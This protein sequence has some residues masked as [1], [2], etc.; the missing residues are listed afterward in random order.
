M[1]GFHFKKNY[2]AIFVTSTILAAIAARILGNCGI[3][4]MELGLL[5]TTLYIVLYII[6]GISLR[7]RIIHTHVRRYLTAVAVLMVF[8]FVVRTMKY[9]FVSDAFISRNLWYS[10]YIPILFIPLLALFVALSLGKPESYRLPKWAAVPAAVTAC[11]TAP[12][13]TNDFHQLVFSFPND[14]V[15]SDK[16]HE[17]TV[18]F[19]LIIGWVFACAIASFA[20]MAYKCRT[21]KRKKYLPVILLVL[22]VIYSFVYSTGV[23]W[24]RIIAGDTAAAQCL[25]FTAI[26]ESCIF[27]G[28]IQTN[29][30]YDSLFKSCTLRM[31]IADKSR[32]IRFSSAGAQALSEELMQGAEKATVPLDKNTLLKSAEIEGGR[33]YWQ[34]DIAELTAVIDELEEN[35]RQ[36]EERNYLAQENYETQRRIISLREKNRLYDILQRHTAPQ[37]ALLD[38]IFAQYEKEADE[39]KRHLL[40]VTAVIG[41]Y[42]K[43][44]GNLLFIGEKNEFVE[45]GELARCIAESLTYLELMGVSCGCDT[46]LNDALRTKDALRAYHTFESIIEAALNSLRFLWLK[47]KSEAEHISLYIE[48]ECDTDLSALSEIADD[49]SAEDG[50]F[51][52]TVRLEKGGESA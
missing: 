32:N 33:V 43:R 52:F 34:E 46:E 24:V 13:L 26:F 27:C 8:W 49:F 11:C 16:N 21:S 28:L 47:A 51:R 37:I 12:V 23:K 36:L 1:T 29:S 30:G 22:E 39:K 17:Y 14:E 20:I 4:P 10:Y 19:Y 44:Y 2:A 9:Y 38:E 15:W 7:T 3:M 25:L 40:A 42:I 6:W 41:A 50:I 35:R 48:A 31:Q 5:R 45:F 18:V